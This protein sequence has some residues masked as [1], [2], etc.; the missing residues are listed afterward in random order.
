M[1]EIKVVKFYKL[2]GEC[3]KLLEDDME[4]LSA[5]ADLFWGFQSILIYQLIIVW[6]GII[7]RLS[8]L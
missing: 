1:H 7:Y 8:M 5:L 4:K 6:K 2:V 3:S